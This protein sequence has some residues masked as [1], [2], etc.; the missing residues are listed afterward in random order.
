MYYFVLFLLLIYYEVWT[1]T[2]LSHFSLVR[3]AGGTVQY[4]YHFLCSCDI[5]MYVQYCFTISSM[6]K[7]KKKKDIPGKFVFVKAELVALNFQCAFLC[8]CCHHTTINCFCQGHGYNPIPSQVLD[9]GFVD[10]SLDDP[11]ILAS[12]HRVSIS[13]KKDWHESDSPKLNAH[14][15]CGGTSQMPPSPEISNPPVAKINFLLHSKVFSSPYL[16][17]IKKNKNKNR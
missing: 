5:A 3:T 2:G 12:E 8:Y 6:K 13:S 11:F 15:R 9:L 16:C 10:N 4:L 1:S 14:F 7:K 17:T